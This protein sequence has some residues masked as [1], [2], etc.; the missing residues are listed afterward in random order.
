[1]HTQ[2]DRQFTHVYK[3]ISSLPLHSATHLSH[4]HTLIHS[5]STTN[6]KTGVDETVLLP[7]KSGPFAFLLPNVLE[8]G[9]TERAAA[10]HLE[11]HVCSAVRR[12]GPFFLSCLGRRGL[13]VRH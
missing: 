6:N 3:N 4:I 10:V 5:A 13:A 12:R 1:M 2:T 8:E 11:F 9:D 7:E